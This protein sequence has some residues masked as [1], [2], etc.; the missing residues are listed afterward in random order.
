MRSRAPLQLALESPF[1]PGLWVVLADVATPTESVSG[2]PGTL[3]L[4]GPSP[5]LAARWCPDSAEP[6]LLVSTWGAAEQ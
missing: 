2:A 1:P 4:L 3:A 6:T 5:R